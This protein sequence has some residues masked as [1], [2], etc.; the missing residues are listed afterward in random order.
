MKFPDPKQYKVEDWEGDS[1]TEAQ[2]EAVRL[3]NEG[4]EDVEVLIWSEKHDSWGLLQELNLER[5]IEPKAGAWNTQVLAPY[6]WR[7]RYKNER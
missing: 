5:G 3:L 7:L 4:Q 2:D 1:W 6:Y